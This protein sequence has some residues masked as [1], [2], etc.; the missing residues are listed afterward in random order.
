M[1]FCSVAEFTCNLFCIIVIVIKLYNI[2]I[3]I[4]KWEGSLNLE[5]MKIVNRK[6]AT[7]F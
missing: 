1:N 2:S 7:K 6:L 5:C 4:T 3:L